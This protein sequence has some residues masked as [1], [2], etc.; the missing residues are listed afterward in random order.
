MAVFAPQGA[1]GRQLSFYQEIRAIDKGNSAAALMATPE[2]V[3]IWMGEKSRHSKG[4]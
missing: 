1:V 2:F 4:R 3:T